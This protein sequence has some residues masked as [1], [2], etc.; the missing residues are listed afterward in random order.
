MSW[1][2]RY[3]WLVVGHL[4][5][6]TGINIAKISELSEALVMIWVEFSKL[7]VRDVSV[8]QRVDNLSLSGEV[9]KRELT[10]PSSLAFLGLDED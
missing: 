8:S 5:G 1:F 3:W 6:I 4:D 2:L 9:N 10:F 7:A